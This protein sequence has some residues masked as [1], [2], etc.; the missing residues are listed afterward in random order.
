MLDC[1]LNDFNIRLLIACCC[2]AFNASNR[3][4]HKV[5]Y[6]I[7]VG[8]LLFVDNLCCEPDDDLAVVDEA[9]LHDFAQLRDE[10]LFFEQQ[11]VG[12]LFRIDQDSSHGLKEIV[13]DL[14]EI[15]GLI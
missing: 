13:V 15:G 8:D 7:L 11:V 2:K 14:L 12:A 1:I 6:Q 5:I 10:L 4:V 3:V 9:G